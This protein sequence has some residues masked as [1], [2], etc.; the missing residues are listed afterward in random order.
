MTETAP[1]GAL[2]NAYHGGVLGIMWY[3][4]RFGTSL[5]LILLRQD[6]T[7]S[8]E[9]LK[10]RVARNSQTNESATLAKSTQSECLQNMRK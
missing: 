3:Q 1:L 8:D 2:L 6:T 7:F 5:R 4:Y 10:G 9:T